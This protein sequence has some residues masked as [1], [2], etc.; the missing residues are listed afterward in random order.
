MQA[1]VTVEQRNLKDLAIL[2]HYLDLFLLLRHMRNKGSNFLESWDHFLSLFGDVLVKS[3]HKLFQFLMTSLGIT[4]P[5]HKHFK[6]RKKSR[7]SYIYLYSQFKIT[8]I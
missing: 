5:I 1:E 8:I 4:F 6:V 2:H 7:I 3:A